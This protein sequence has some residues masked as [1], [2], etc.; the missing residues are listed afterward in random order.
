MLKR[1]RFKS[2]SKGVRLFLCPLN[3]DKV[4]TLLLLGNE[5]LALLV[6]KNRKYVFLLLMCANLILGLTQ[7]LVGGKKI[8]IPPDHNTVSGLNQERRNYCL[9]VTQY[10]TRSETM[11][12][13]L[14]CPALF[15]VQV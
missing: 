11:I 14:N 15:I 6:E 4:L 10:H 13:Q 7:Q 8:R 12:K 5:Y 9:F 1:A 3:G 2:E